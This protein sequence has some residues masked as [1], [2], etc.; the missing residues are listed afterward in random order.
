MRRRPVI[1][2]PTQTLPSIEGI[3]E[4]LPESWVM[5][6]R[7]SRV[8]ATAGVLVG[9]LAGERILFGLGPRQFRR[10][11]AA[12]VGLLGIWLIVQAL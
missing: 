3:P 9:T 6:Q 1:G 10:A 5:N 12:L 11:I 4:V 7:Y 2:I 8:V